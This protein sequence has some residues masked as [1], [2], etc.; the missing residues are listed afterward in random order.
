M[1]Q[2]LT[3]LNTAVAGSPA[4]ALGAAAAW[5]ILSILL[6]PCHLASIPLIVGFLGS[7]ADLTTRRALGLSS[8][9]AAGIL[10]TIAIVGVITAAL[11][12]LW[13]DIGATGNTLVAV[14]FFVV[15][16]HLLDVIPLPLAPK[17]PGK[18]ERRGA[19]GAFLLGLVFGVALGPCS[20]AFMVP[21]TGVAFPIARKAPL[22]AAGLLAAYGLGHCGVIAIA[23]G[24]AEAVQRYLNW[25][26]GS[27]AAALL[28]KACG[29]LV[30]LGGVYL[31]LR[32]Q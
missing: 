5:G 4:L 17:G 12:R 29:V 3:A 24:S 9:F 32:V 2:L 6:S 8:A 19:L 21:V 28:R 15:G 22:F 1:E 30:I 14:V 25:D 26:R 10:V 16:L 13:G 11:G 20:F 27:R 18:M 7:Q 31:I 23:G